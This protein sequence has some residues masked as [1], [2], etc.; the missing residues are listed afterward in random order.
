MKICFYGFFSY[1][2]KLY[3]GSVVDCEGDRYSFEHYH[4]KI[5][6]V[7]LQKQE[8]PD[9]CKEKAIPLAY[10]IMH[11]LTREQAIKRIAEIYNEFK[12]QPVDKISSKRTISDY[13]KYVKE[14]IENYVKN[15]LVFDSGMPGNVK[16]GLAYNYVC[17][18]N[19]LVLDPID[20]GTKF[21]Y[22]FL[23]QNNYNIESIGYV[24]TW[25]AQFDKYFT[26]DYETSF[27]K[28]FLSVFEKMFEVLNWLDK[29]DEIP[30]TAIVNVNKFLKR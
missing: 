24:G 3:I 26:I 5:K 29:G 6:G 28:F 13:A 11:G 12:Q 27:R 25:P 18:K 8:F 1:A 22:V 2:K 15:G 23:N 21:N 4:N 20:R 7:V 17:A 16:M 14:P 30:L 19:K 9:F 10:D